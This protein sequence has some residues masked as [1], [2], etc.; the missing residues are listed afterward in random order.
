V[1]GVP[2]AIWIWHKPGHPG[3]KNCCQKDRERKAV[4]TFVWGNFVDA[5][6]SGRST[7][8]VSEE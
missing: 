6:C 5:E 1:K 4:S 3:A 7:D 8:T 2:E